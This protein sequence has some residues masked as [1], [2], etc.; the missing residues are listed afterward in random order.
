MTQNE[1]PVLLAVGICRGRKNSHL[2]K[3]REGGA[4]E[5]MANLFSEPD[6]SLFWHLDALCCFT[7]PT[8]LTYGADLLCATTTPVSNSK[9][10]STMAS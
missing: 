9:H 4:L 8:S 5:E 7:A 2:H 10:L 1:Q 6:L 3:E